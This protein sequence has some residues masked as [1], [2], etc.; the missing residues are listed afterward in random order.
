MAQIPWLGLRFCRLRC[1]WPHQTVVLPLGKR[2]PWGL[3][4]LA[5]SKSMVPEAICGCLPFEAVHLM[6]QKMK[7]TFYSNILKNHPDASW[8]WVELGALD[9]WHNLGVGGG[10]RVHGRRFNAQKCFQK[11]VSLDLKNAKIWNNLGILGGGEVRG[12]KLTQRVCF[13]YALELDSEDAKVWYN[14]GI[15]GGGC[16]K[17]EKFSETACFQKALEFDSQLSDAWYHLGLLGGGEVKDA[18]FDAEA[19]LLMSVKLDP[20]NFVEITK[21]PRSECMTM[22]TSTEVSR[23]S[24]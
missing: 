5:R 24:L 9:A 13:Q 3:P 12:Q 16:V 1:S 11:A 19:C 17:D 23:E 18:I 22:S 21:P 15:I 2:P 7:K 14:L 20:E 8:A 10:G 4:S 6:M